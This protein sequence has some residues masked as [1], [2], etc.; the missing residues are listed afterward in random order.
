MTTDPAG[1]PFADR[2]GVPL[3]PERDGYHWLA[4]T[5]GDQPT[6]HTAVM[7]WFAG[8]GFYAIEAVPVTQRSIVSGWRYLGPCLTP[9]EVTA[10]VEQARCE[11]AE[12]MREGAATFLQCCAKAL[13]LKDAEQ[14]GIPDHMGW[15]LEAHAADAWAAAIRDLPLPHGPLA[16]AER[17][18]EA[19]GRVAGLREAAA[20]VRVHASAA[21]RC[22]DEGDV[23][24][25]IRAEYLAKAFALNAAADDIEAAILAL[26]EK[27]GA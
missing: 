10:L 3:N 7:F 23:I 20:K 26:A 17:A 19:R 11:G 18:A 27:E 8:T 2:P 5:D 14:R 12:A 24:H 15:S 16:A 22:S 21:K 25:H 6:G 9:D 13:R 1:W 4:A